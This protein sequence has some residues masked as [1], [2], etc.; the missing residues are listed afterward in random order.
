M[1]LRGAGAPSFPRKASAPFGLRG[2]CAHAAGV[3]AAA[4]VR[5]D[6]SRRISARLRR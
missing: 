1:C 4:S 2:A 6:A 3:S 5:I